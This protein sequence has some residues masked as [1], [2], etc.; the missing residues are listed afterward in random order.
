MRFRP[1]NGGQ[2]V[3]TLLVYLNTPGAGGCTSFPS[4]DVCFT[5]SQ[6]TALLFFPAFA[7][8]RLDA[9]ALHSADPAV[10]TKWVSQV[11]VRQNG[12][13]RDAE[14]SR[15]A[16]GTPQQ[17][18]PAESHESSPSSSDADEPAEQPHTAPKA[19]ARSGDVELLGALLAG[20]HVRQDAGA[21]L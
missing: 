14:P 2:R 9:R 6:G 19:A 20:M 10:A 13:R 4:L 16:A 8:G 17:A 15:R 5:P 18:A 12:Q 7:D 1:Q 3:V 21:P 11:W